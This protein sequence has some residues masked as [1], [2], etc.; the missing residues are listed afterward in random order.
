VPRETRE[1]VEAKERRTSRKV[2]EATE[3]IHATKS[4]DKIAAKTAT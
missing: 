4:E 3:K 1:V 2:T